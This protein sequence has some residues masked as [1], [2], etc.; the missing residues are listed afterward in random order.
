MTEGFFKTLTKGRKNCL[1]KDKRRTPAVST[2]KKKHPYGAF[3]FSKMMKKC[4]F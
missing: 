4:I 1:E 3:F 2:I